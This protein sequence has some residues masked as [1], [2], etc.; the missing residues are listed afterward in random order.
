MA[1]PKILIAED[2][3][4]VRLTLEF[5]LADEG[6]DVLLAEDGEQALRLARAEAPD[7]ILLDNMMP[8]LDG[9]QVFEA[10]KG[11]MATSG[12]PVVI[13]TGMTPDKS[14]EWAGAHFVLKPFA[15]GSLVASIREL[16]E[17]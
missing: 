10:L 16:L 7:L 3:A 1:G 14:D 17:T 9:R 2:D 6:F 4:G 15:P 13:L 5:I 8:K 12:I 11:E